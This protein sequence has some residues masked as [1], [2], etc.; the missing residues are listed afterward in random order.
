[1]KHMKEF[2]DR[3]FN[4]DFFNNGIWTN[5]YLGNELKAYLI[6]LVIFLILSVVFVILKKI[7]MIQIKKLV[8]RTINQIDDTIYESLNCI[9]L[10]FLFYLA[11]YISIQGLNF[12]YYIHEISHALLVIFGVWQTIEIIN[13]GVNYLLDKHMKDQD[14][15]YTFIAGGLISAFTRIGLWILGILFILS[16][17]GIN[18]VSLVAGLGIGGAAIALASQNILEDLFSSFVIF[19]DKPF[20][21][22]DFIIVGE[23]M[24]TVKRIGIKT[25]R[26]KALDGEEI[27]ITNKELTSA[28]IQNYKRMKERRISFDF[29]VVYQTPDEHV[30]AIPGLIRD[31]IESVKMTRF[32]RC[33]FKSF[34]ESSLA[35]ETVYFVTS[36][37]YNKYMDVNQEIHNEIKKVFGKKGISMAYPTRTVYVEKE[38]DK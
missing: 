7:V 1:M 30:K 4:I 28:R 24:G 19:F 20:R 14:G 27:V 25:T 37:D 22:G 10:S 3:L 34:D 12:G 15:E 32:D 8:K 11:F 26:I 6:A 36:G 5:T 21:V 2:F 38:S 16:N 33:H 29:G 17:L 23:D 13:V 35:F 31:I 9:K 18:I